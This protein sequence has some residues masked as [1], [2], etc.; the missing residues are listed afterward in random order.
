MSHP[1]FPAPLVRMGGGEGVKGNQ[2]A[3]PTH[4][5]ETETTAG[6]FL[7]SIFI[8]FVTGV[9]YSI[10]THLQ[11][12]GYAAPFTTTSMTGTRR[13][14]I[15]RAECGVDTGS[16]LL[17][18]RNSD[19]GGRSISQSCPQ[20]LPKPEKQDWWVIERHTRV[21]FEMLASGHQSLYYG[22]GAPK[23]RVWWHW[24][25]SRIIHEKSIIFE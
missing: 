12:Y 15:L 3:N 9:Q 7:K 21:C 17:M 4:E 1:L 16:G 8:A 22:F 18:S 2:W 25:A 19:R 13:P 14:F 20:E 23:D 6:P 11:I 24:A 10:W 5:P